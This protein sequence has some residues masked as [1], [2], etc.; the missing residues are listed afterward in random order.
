MLTMPMDV[1]TQFP[2]RKSRKQ[3]QSFREAVT[4]YA[5]NFGYTCRTEKGSFGSHNLVIGDPEK[6]EYLV[7]AHYDTPARMLI[8]N[9][10]TPCNPVTF[11]AYQLLM[12]ALFFVG[13]F[14][15][16]IPVYLLTDNQQIAFLAGYVVYFGL[17]FLM[18]FGPANPS[19]ANDNTSGVVTVLETLRTFPENQ[20]N[21][22][23]FV[24]F[25]LE[26]AGLIGSASYRKAHKAA[27]DRQIVLNLDCV[28]D[29]NEIV[30]FPVKKLCA[31]REKMIRLCQ[32]VGRFGS[33][34]IAVCN[35]GFRV[36]PSDQRNFP[37]GVGI[38]AFR[39][40][41]GVGLYCAKIHTAKDTTLDQTNVN[42]LRAALTSYISGNAAQ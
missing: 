23:C 30:F 36:Y 42:I 4:A 15:V 38:A 5:E 37:Y 39:R 29:G 24:L 31:D 2:V 18:L 12:V 7:T 17:L 8:P 16:G 41:K 34:T 33:K 6:A 3:K 28:G 22:I 11:I 21:K 10:I 40:K 27:T 14:A 25:D 19:N 35:K 1:L 9:L 20:R 26:E 32:C 13:A